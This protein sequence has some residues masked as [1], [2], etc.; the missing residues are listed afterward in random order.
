[1]YK[2]H[3]NVLF[4]KRKC[5]T[6]KFNICAL[7]WLNTGIIWIITHQVIVSNVNC[8]IWRGFQTQFLFFH[9]PKA[10][11]IF[12]MNFYIIIKQMSM[13]NH[14]I[15]RT[16]FIHKIPCCIYYLIVLGHFFNI[17]LHAHSSSTPYHKGRKTA[18]LKVSFYYR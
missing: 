14:K 5:K 16:R 6:T 11:P 10:I 12:L 15:K 7:L 2:K 1:M 4:S 17:R 3:G 9:E 13:D 8:A 18:D